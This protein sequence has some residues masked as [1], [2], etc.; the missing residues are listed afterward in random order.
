LEAGRK[1]VTFNEKLIDNMTLEEQLNIMGEN[2]E[3]E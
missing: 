3:A 2:K 1:F